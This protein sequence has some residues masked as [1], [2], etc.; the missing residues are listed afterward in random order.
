[1][2]CHGVAV[3]SRAGVRRNVQSGNTNKEKRSPYPYFRL[4]LLKGEVEE[5]ANSHFEFVFL[6]AFLF[7]VPHLFAYEREALPY[8]R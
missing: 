7:D 2:S 3:T 6:S 5:S 4:A 8:R 1:M